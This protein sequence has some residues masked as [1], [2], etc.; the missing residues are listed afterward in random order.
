MCR[1]FSAAKMNA[2]NWLLAK[3][4]NEH[5][6]SQ[7][8]PPAGAALA[9][10][11]FL[12]FLCTIFETDIERYKQKLSGEDSAQ[13]KWMLKNVFWLRTRMQ[14]IP[15][16]ICRRPAQHVPQEGSL[17]TSNTNTCQTLCFKI[18]LLFYSQNAKS[19]KNDWRPLSVSELWDSLHA[20]HVYYN[21]LFSLSFSIAFF[22]AWTPKK[23][24]YKVCHVPGTQSIFLR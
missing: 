8:F 12:C 16:H 4:L 2:K 14:K 20:M 11:H 18:P 1:I 21:W 19:E 15:C 6:A 3:N 24:R 9:A 23:R 7:H 10:S 13:R 22:P 5:H 17:T